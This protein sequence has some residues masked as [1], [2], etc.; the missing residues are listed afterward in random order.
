MSG[1]EIGTS[2]SV[3]Q[4]FSHS[5]CAM[6]HLTLITLD[7]FISLVGNSHFAPSPL[8]LLLFPLLSTPLEWDDKVL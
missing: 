3:F 4:F 8:P 5:L 7:T 2:L 1:D 6:Q